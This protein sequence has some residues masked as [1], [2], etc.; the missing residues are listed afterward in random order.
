M[1]SR[2]RVFHRVA[3]HPA[4]GSLVLLD[5]SIDIQDSWLFQVRFDL[6]RTSYLLH[7]KS[8]IT[9]GSLHDSIAYA[10]SIDAKVWKDMLT[11]TK[12][13]YIT[14]CSLKAPWDKAVA[15]LNTI[16]VTMGLPKDTFPLSDG[17]AADYG[18]LMSRI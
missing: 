11:N 6:Q 14:D 5:M 2:L 12:R 4:C 3:N 17:K 9:T 1:L 18:C 16:A 13:G 15:E 8:P 7:R 10:R